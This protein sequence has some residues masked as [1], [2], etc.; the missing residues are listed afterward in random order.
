M[1][2]LG[3]VRSTGKRPGTAGWIVALGVVATA[4]TFVGPS[5]AKALEE[6]ERYCQAT[7]SPRHPL[8]LTARHNTFS[9]ECLATPKADGIRVVFENADPD[10][11]SFSIYAPE[12]AKPKTAA[13]A[14]AKD[15]EKEKGPKALFSSEPFNGWR[16]AEYRIDG[17]DTGTYRFQCDV[18]PD[19]MFGDF[20]VKEPKK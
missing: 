7:N 3:N 8:Q 14:D 12:P 13:A 15:A 11:H 18:H 20:V 5:T 16:T 17:L 4:V 9:V 2:T 1:G 6:G 19:D 10:E